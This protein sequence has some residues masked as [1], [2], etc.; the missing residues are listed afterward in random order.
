MAGKE[1]TDNNLKLLLHFA[2]LHANE[3]GQPDGQELQIVSSVKIVYF[4]NVLKCAIF[5]QKFCVV[6]SL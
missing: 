4:I 3:F 6:N 1:V 2:I 5:Y